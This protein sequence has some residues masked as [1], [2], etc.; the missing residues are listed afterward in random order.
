MLRSLTMRTELLTLTGLSHLTQHQDEHGDYVVQTTPTDPNY[1][2]GNQLIL[3]D[4]SRSA[5]QTFALFEQN[6]PNASHHA[7]VWDVPNADPAPLLDG[8]ASLGCSLKALMH[9]C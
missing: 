5:K 3:T 9:C 6:F 7:A 4:L 8:F 1:W 2:F